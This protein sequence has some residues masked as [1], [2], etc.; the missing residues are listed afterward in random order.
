M[1]SD[2]G[3]SRA[4]NEAS[5]LRRAIDFADSARDMVCGRWVAGVRE[6]EDRRRSQE[7]NKVEVMQKSS[8]AFFGSV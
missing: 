4:R 1:G 2:A 6:G 7:S 8:G 5:R 3:D